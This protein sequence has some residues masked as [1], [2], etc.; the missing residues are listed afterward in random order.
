VGICEAV[1]T[2]LLVLL[3][4]GI[5]RSA[6]RSSA[7]ISSKSSSVCLA[8]FLFFWT[9]YVWSVL[10]ACNELVA[11]V[12]AVGLVVSLV[13]ELVPEVAATLFFLPILALP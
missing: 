13:L 8:F 4:V 12:E 7:S 9:R 2:V 3:T 1:A 5:V 11:T 10:G 6:A